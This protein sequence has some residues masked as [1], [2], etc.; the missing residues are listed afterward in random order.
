[1]I[2]FASES[3]AMIQIGDIEN[4]ARF[5]DMTPLEIRETKQ[6]V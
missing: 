6:L 2:N 1:M 5:Y 3:Y 4:N